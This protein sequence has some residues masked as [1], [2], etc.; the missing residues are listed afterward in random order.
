MK[1]R[2]SLIP[3]IFA[4]AVPA[5]GIVD[6]LI[7]E[8]WADADR[9]NQDI[10]ANSLAWYSSSGAS[11]VVVGAGFLT[12]NTGSSG[13]HLVAYFTPSG[14]PAEI[15]VGETMQVQFTVNFARA[16]PLGTG[17]DFR[18]G[19]WNS[20]GERVSVDSH[21]GTS[22]GSPNAAF[23]NYTGYIFAGGVDASRSISLR[24]KPAATDGILIASTSPYITLG[25]TATDHT[26][27]VPNTDYYGL[28]SLSR[29]SADTLSISYTMHD[30]TTTFTSISRDDGDTPY[31]AFDT[32][33][34]IIGGNVADSFTLRQVEISIVPEPAHIALLLGALGLLGV[35]LRRRRGA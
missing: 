7:N 16:T 32:V 8:T 2:H 18:M 31:V 15:A 9:L 33:A 22:S 1:L 10:P 34:F 23:I 14:T 21:A 25:T 26:T 29:V 5:F 28:L 17:N 20:Q 35:L 24:K 12:Q 4:G 6:V 13:R 27:L 3:L 19:V 30:G 11:N